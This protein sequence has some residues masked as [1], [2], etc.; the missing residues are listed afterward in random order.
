M[1]TGGP[2]ADTQRLYWRPTQLV[3][4]FVRYYRFTKAFCWKLLTLLLLSPSFKSA[5]SDMSEAQWECLLEMINQNQGSFELI[6]KTTRPR[7][8]ILLKIMFQVLGITENIVN[9]P[10]DAWMAMNNWIYAVACANYDRTETRAPKPGEI[11]GPMSERYLNHPQRWFV[12][13]DKQ[14]ILPVNP[15]YVPIKESQIYTQDFTNENDPRYIAWDCDGLETLE[16]YRGRVCERCE[17]KCF[18]KCSCN[19]SRVFPEPLVE[20]IETDGKGL[21][22]RSLQVRI[23]FPQCTPSSQKYANV[24]GVDH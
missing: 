13:I 6:S 10:S 5:A 11:E 14:S 7:Y 8:G 19:F 15:V 1:L 2:P 12:A 21:G 16:A 4:S 3:R 24:G 22:V 18:A 9:N 20:I 17:V 23:L